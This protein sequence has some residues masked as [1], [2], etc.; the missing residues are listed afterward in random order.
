MVR[1][2]GLLIAGAAVL[3]PVAALCWMQY[4]SLD[5][6]ESKTR[7]VVR[8]R[9]R[10]RLELVRHDLESRIA[11]IASDA[12]GAIDETN[13]AGKLPMA[14]AKW[15]EIDRAFLVSQCSCQRKP[16][17]M[18]D[19]GNADQAEICA[20]LDAFRAARPSGDFEYF[21]YQRQ[22]GSKSSCGACHQAGWIAQRE[23]AVYVFRVLPGAAKSESSSFAGVR[24]PIDAVRERLLPQ[25]V[26]ALRRQDGDAL[27]KAALVTEAAATGE[28]V[29]IH[30][31]TVL[32]LWHLVGEYEGS[33]IHSLARAQLSRSLWL[34]TFLLASLLAGI[35]FTIR[36]AA[37][38][39]QLAAMKSAFVSNISHEMK[40]PLAAIRASAETLQLGRVT[41]NARMGHYF[42]AIHSESLRLTELIDNVLDLARM[43]S[44][45]RPSRRELAD[46][47]SLVEAICEANRGHILS[48]GFQFSVTVHRPLPPVRVDSRAFHTA[49]ANLL[50]N[51]VKYSRDAKR[52]EV[53]VW[54]NGQR[55]N[56]SVA[57]RGIG[58]APVDQRH[59]FDRFYRAGDPLVHD[60]K[61]A[62]LGLALAREIAGAHKGS[63]EV[64]SRPG[65][66]STF[67]ICLPFE[68]TPLAETTHC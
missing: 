34:W 50:S 68:A 10:H 65:Q 57:D 49:V 31:G 36:A 53:R 62:G 42:Q 59:I 48:Q 28:Q 63:I 41:D 3:L 9:L 46:A 29:A 1:N 64:R 38:E 60:V 11:A 24:I 16:V 18:V 25:S 12:L 22:A 66:G 19:S 14:R 15:P 67:T 45:D 5:E 44:A 61:G 21:Q 51:A 30:A 33:T 17:A 8:D 47:G 58:I 52:I 39:A 23:S 20:L 7:V 26:A 13:A 40:T 32:S 4:R 43:E 54:A 2:R 37:R 27:W 35:A 55:V 56:V 6:L